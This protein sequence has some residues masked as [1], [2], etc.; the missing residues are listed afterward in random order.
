MR[1]SIRIGE[2][3]GIEI[4]LDY[5]WFIIF[6]WI[7]WS[8]AGH[9]LVVYPGW[10]LPLRLALAVA[11]AILFFGSILAHEFGHSLVASGAGVPVKRVTLFIFGG[12]A[13]LEHEPRQA[14]DELMIAMAG[15]GV[16]LVLAS[17]FGLMW[18][19]GRLFEITTL[20]ALGGWLGGINLSLALFNLIPGFP[21]DGGRILRAVIWKL[22]GN[23]RGATQAGVISG[24]AVA[25]M[26]ILLGV[27]QL[28]AG[29]WANGLWIAFIGWFLNNAA[30]DSARKMML[31]E[32]LEGHTVQEV[33]TTDC[34]AVSPDL[35]LSRLVSDFILADNRRCFPVMEGEHL[36]GLISMEQVKKV[37]HQKW[38]TTTVRHAMTPNSQLTKLTPDEELYFALEQMDAGK[39]NQLPVME[40]HQLLGVLSRDRLMDY[41]HIR[42]E[43]AVVSGNK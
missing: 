10:S 23:M 26:F 8:L 30:V 18:I 1:N 14:R 37:S 38:A 39:V 40:G 25:W 29:D 42:S 35:E 36:A 43:M 2:I 34:P 27:W 41:I 5:S 22:T 28:S 21:L 33:M 16:S 31:K 9:Y 3:F 12:M 19:S 11:T 13:H 32:L 15:P 6:I 17:I 24:Q 7:A 4:R 20:A